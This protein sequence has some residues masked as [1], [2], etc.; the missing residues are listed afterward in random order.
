MILNN[1][2]YRIVMFLLE[3]NTY[4]TVE[5][6]SEFLDLSKRSVYYSINSINSMLDELG[7]ERITSKRNY[8][9][10]LPNKSRALLRKYMND[11][12]KVSRQYY[13]Y[14]QREAIIVTA[15]YKKTLD[16]E[17]LASKC[18]VSLRTI[19]DDIKKLEATLSV[20]RVAVSCKKNLGYRLEGKMIHVRAAVMY[21]LETIILLNDQQLI[22]EMWYN[23]SLELQ[24]KLEKVEKKADLH[25]RNNFVFRLAY[26]INDCSPQKQ[27]FD[28]YQQ[29]IVNHPVF[30]IVAQELKELSFDN[31]YY[32]TMVISSE[33]L[34]K[35]EPSVIENLKHNEALANTIERM[36]HLYEELG[37]V[38]FTDYEHLWMSLAQHIYFSQRLYDNGLIDVNSL[39]EEIKVE[40]RTVYMLTEMVLNKFQ[41]ELNYPITDDEIAYMT[42]LFGAHLNWMKNYPIR[43]LIV[44]AN[45]VSTSLMIKQEVLRMSSHVEVVATVSVSNLVNYTGMFD[46]IISTV[47]IETNL[48]VVLVNPIFTQFDRVRVMNAVE[49]RNDFFQSN[50][51][52]NNLYNRLEPYIRSEFLKEVR[53]ILDEYD[54]SRKLRGTRNQEVGIRDIDDVIVFKRYDGEIGWKES[55]KSV[56]DELVGNGCI[57]FSYVEACICGIVENGVYSVFPNNMYLAH[58]KPE[59]GVNMLSLGVGYYPSGVVFPDDT[60]IHFVAILAPT[61]YHTHIKI[62]N[63]VVELFSNS[64]FVTEIEETV[65]E[66]RDFTKMI[67]RYL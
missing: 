47:R 58:A 53:D 32:V 54:A 39:K 38:S 62:L 41:D 45:G 55:I 61:D 7:Y 21:Y 52:I 34:S 19:Q 59:D 2:S 3:E 42:L 36:I 13:T 48:P 57:E 60:K 12:E 64:A 23:D 6:I 40:Y 26:V 5:M 16:L 9:I 14:Q 10:L 51:K 22:D 49:S 24:K 43:V 50:T 20:F 66:K 29:E 28:R 33:R 1:N 35:L 17:Q 37:R 4:S 65:L 18:N 67:E 27:I 63:Q 25:L 44:C 31:Q 56:G 15:I 11:N 30:T 46:L 8:G